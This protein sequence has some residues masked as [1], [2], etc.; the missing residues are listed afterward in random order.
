MPGAR[1]KHERE[2][3]AKIPWKSPGPVSQPSHLSEHALWAGAVRSTLP[4]T[5]PQGRFG[6]PSPVTDKETEAREVKGLAVRTVAGIQSQAV[7]RSLSQVAR[8]VG[9]GPGME[10]KPADP[11]PVP[12][13]YRS[14]FPTKWSSTIASRSERPSL[15]TILPSPPS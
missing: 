10:S 15:T 7:G 2:I 13:H 14:Y 9:A 6:F 1:H 12:V 4:P 11:H 8:L 3:L 5:A